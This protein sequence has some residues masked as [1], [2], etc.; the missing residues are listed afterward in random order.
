MHWLQN[1]SVDHYATNDLRQLTIPAL[2][3]YFILWLYAL[4]GNDYLLNLVQWTAALWSM[5]LVAVIVRRLTKNWVPAVVALILSISMPIGIAESTTTQSDWLAALWVIIAMGLLVERRR[6]ALRFKAFLVLLATT[7]ALVGATKPTG[8]ASMAVVVPIVAFAELHGNR[9][10]FKD[11]ALRCVL[12]ALGAC[13]GLFI[14]VLPQAIRNSKTFGSI[15]GDTYGLLVEGPNFVSL[16]G[17]SLRIL[18]NNVGIPSVFSD[19]LNPQIEPL[20]NTIRIQWVDIAAVGYEHLPRISLARNEDLATNPIQ[21]FG[22]LLAATLLIFIVKGPRLIRLFA[23]AGVGMFLV[24]AL[25]WKWNIWTNRFLI[26]AMLI[27]IVP[28]A[29]VIWQILCLSG[30]RSF[31][32]RIT[33]KSLIV[34]ASIYG[35]FVATT[36]QYRPLFDSSSVLTTSRDDR[37]F[38]V[39]GEEQ[40]VA[41]PN[42]QKQLLNVAPGSIVGLELKGI[43][44]YPIWAL[45]NHDRRYKFVHAR[46]GNPSEIYEIDDM[47]I[48]LCVG[49]CSEL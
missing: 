39:L 48:I 36:L 43:D 44:E 46:V 23:L 12:V 11:R 1:Q 21:L 30:R 35:L 2:S 22:G 42:L 15:F 31:L 41:V 37:Y 47:D 16:I 7:V 26:Q 33:T 25:V 24:N 3:G 13:V 8:V 6:G 10:G 4:S 17:N 19:W 14:G 27:M 38:T 28:F 20:F 40:K 29:Y 18:I 32:L 9:I 45:L 5:I 49:H 34:F